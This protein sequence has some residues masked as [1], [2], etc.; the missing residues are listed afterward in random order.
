MAI[1]QTTHVLKNSDIVNR[2]LPASLLKGEPIINTADGIMYFSGVTTSTSEWT[3]AGTGVTEQTFFEVGS[4]LYD[5]RL[6]NRLTQYEGQSGGSLTGKF[7]SGTSTGFVLADISNI[8]GID[9]YVTGSTF[10]AATNDTNTQYSE[11]QYNIPLAGGPYFINTEDTFTTGGTYDNNTKLITFDKNDATSFTVDLISIDTNDTY[12]TGGTNTAAT[13]SSP[14]GTISLLYNQDVVPGTYSL[15]YSDVFLTGFTYLNNNFTLL[16][17]SGN[18]YSQVVNDFTGLT[19]NG[20][21]TVTG[22]TSL[23]G[24]TATTISATTYQNLPVTADT[25]T[26]GF[27]YSDNT[28]TIARNQGL[29]SLTATINTVTGLTINGNLTVTGNT[30]LNA[31]TA[32]TISATTITADTITATDYLNLPSPDDLTIEVVNDFVR[33]KDIVSA[34]T[35]GTRTFLGNIVVASGFTATTISATTYQNLPTDVRVTGATYNNNT[36][37]Y[38]NNT[39]GTFNVSFNTV[40]GL[41]VNGNLTVTG[42]TSLQGLS[43]TTI[44]ATTYQNLPATTDTFTTGFTYSD[45]TFTIS[46]NQGQPDLTAT[47]NTVTGLTINGDLTTTGTTS[48]QTL[49]ATSVF[50]SGFVPT[51]VV[52]VGSSGELIGENAFTYTEGTH[53]LNV[54]NIEASGDVVVQGSLTVFGPSVSAF[55]S[56]LYV[57]DPNVTLNYNPTGSTTVTSVNAGITI[58]DGNGVSS[59]DVNLDIVRMSNFTGLT[60]TEIP[61]VTEYTALTGYSNRGWVTQLNDIVIRST[62]PTDDGLFN[63]I[64]VLGEFDT[65]DGGV[66]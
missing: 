8:Q 32:N 37:T 64:R 16:D 48:L 29:P 28:F 38:T 50:V 10:T 26:T 42:N 14:N 53:T 66:Y 11:L 19:I 22:N 21:L 36:F 2:P 58:Q 54:V 44:S 17:N 59:G 62:D 9:R 20:N 63:G 61:S 15:P 45:N 13:T 46:R 35:G 55:T 34:P 65:L 43:A 47:I 1:R 40:T 56:N 12:V 39:G 49:S 51:Q 57:E 4:N 31:L 27:T 60:S 24:L 3:P 52:Y 25:F 6:R 41:T 7:L 23:Q 33:L 30:S 5:L 18:T